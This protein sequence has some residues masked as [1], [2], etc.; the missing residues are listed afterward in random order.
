MIAKHSYL[1]VILLAAVLFM[2]ASPG[3]A[4]PAQKQA[5]APAQ[6][7]LP[8]TFKNFSFGPGTVTGRVLNA[9]VPEDPYVGN[10]L[11]CSGSNCVLSNDG[12]NDFPIGEYTL[13]NVA[14]GRQTLTASADGFI[15]TTQTTFV[16]GNTV[17]YQDIAIIPDVTRSGVQYR[18]MVTWD[19]T[20]CWP[21]PN[22]TTCWDNDLDLHMW[23][24]DI[25]TP[26]IHYHIGY[27]YHYDPL[28]D[29]EDFWLDPGD[30]RSFPKACLEMDARKG[31]GP[32]T[33]AIREREVARYYFGVF[34]TNQG[35]PGVPPI[36]QTKALVRLYDKT[37][38][39]K[40]YQVSPAGGDKVFWYVFSL[41]EAG[42][43]TDQNCIIDYISDYDITTWP[44]CP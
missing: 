22:G 35:R 30:C 20:P 11:V 18:V 42:E 10:A 14:N 26:T 43:V 3:L 32:E 4:R 38:L 7:W 1:R 12:V 9:S 27:F 24:F 28:T 19:A 6:V 16:V 31:Y 37:G 23:R 2:L 39:V 34:N 8:I 36:S 33:I 5:D 13:E 44:T 17:N 29:I 15:T 41:D 21:D 40:S 25:N